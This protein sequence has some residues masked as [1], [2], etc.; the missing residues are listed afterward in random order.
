MKKE[1]E[2]LIKNYKAPVRVSKVIT[3]AQPVFLAGIAGAGKDTIKNELLKD[4]RFRHLVS[5]TT[6]PK[7]VNNGVMERDGVEYHFIDQVQL[8]EMLDN[9]RFI[10]VKQVHDKIY[11]TSLAE[12]ERAIDNNQLPITDIDI[13]GVAEYHDLNHN[14]RGIFILPPSFE[15]WKGRFFN[16]Y[17]SL[18]E[19]EQNW[20]LRKETAINELEYI[21]SVDYY[22]FV[23]ND[24]LEQAVKQIKESIFDGQKLLS[25]NQAEAIIKDL[26]QKL[27]ES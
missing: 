8:Q 7:R 12:F 3:Q 27:K 20:A 6:R 2:R 19:F 18:E 26:L 24:D 5:H 15:V 4:D 21:L 17:D 11:G 14:L 23:L 16:R 22:D 13:Q 1:L 10:E 25:K 9:K